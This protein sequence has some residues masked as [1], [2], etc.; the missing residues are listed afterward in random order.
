MSLTWF[1]L[2]KTYLSLT[3][4]KRVQ[5]KRTILSFKSAKSQRFW[6]KG[7]IE[8][9]SVCCTVWIVLIHVLPVQYLLKFPDWKRRVVLKFAE[10][11]TKFIQF[12]F[13]LEVI[14]TET[15]IFSFCQ[16]INL[17]KNLEALSFK[18]CDLT[19][20]HGEKTRKKLFL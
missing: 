2:T 11:W 20:Y 1:I 16:F 8:S 14:R 3:S 9:C 15:I 7:R 6:N 12:I 5:W 4:F 19:N 18:K 13:C 10:K 17:S